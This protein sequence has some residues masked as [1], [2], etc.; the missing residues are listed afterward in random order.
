[1]L[2][3]K[4]GFE[5][6]LQS[7][8]AEDAGALAANADDWEVAYCAAGIGEFPIPYTVMDALRLIEH[9]NSSAACG[10]ERHFGVHT[11]DGRLVGA[12][13]VLDI[14]EKEKSCRIGYWL[15][16]AHWGKG[17]GRQAV[18]LLSGFCSDGLGMRKAYAHVFGFNSRSISLLEGLG[19]SR[20]D[21]PS[22]LVAHYSGYTEEERFSKSLGDVT[23]E[24]GRT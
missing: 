5:V 1:M 2:V 13:A 6:Y 23:Y 10:G 20:E 4:K 24:N 9:A 3:S 21:T 12:V 22:R 19:F 8:S 17:Y 15:G 14:N 7:L 11:S 16:K 18:S